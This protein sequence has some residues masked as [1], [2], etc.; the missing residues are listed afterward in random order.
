M[1]LPAPPE[2]V[3]YRG[4]GTQ[5]SSNCNILTL[6]MKRRKGSW[7]EKG[8]NNMA[9]ILCY[10]HTVG[11]DVM[12]GILPEAVGCGH[13]TEPLSAAKAP[14]RDGKGDGGGWMRAD[15]PF[16]QTFRTNGRRAIRGLLGQRPLS[17]LRG[18]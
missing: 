2:G 3:T 17:D 1:E 16:D 4:L 11:F 14:F 6:R 8:A 12:L 9:R 13:P 7:T 5:E 18:I 15:M 10:R